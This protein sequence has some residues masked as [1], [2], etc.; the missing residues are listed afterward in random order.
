M[1]LSEI[2]AQLLPFEQKIYQNERAFLAFFK[3]GGSVINHITFCNVM[4]HIMWRHK[5]TQN[6]QVFIATIGQ[7]QDFFDSLL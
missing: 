5:E 2:T 3:L 4:C 1:K 7:I 6:T